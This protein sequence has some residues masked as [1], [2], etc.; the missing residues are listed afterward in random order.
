MAMDGA[1]SARWR[2]CRPN[3]TGATRPGPATSTGRWSTWPAGWGSGSSGRSRSPRSAALGRGEGRLPWWQ[4][5]PLL[6]RRLLVA[7]GSGPFAHTAVPPT[8][9]RPRSCWQGNDDGQG[10]VRH[11]AH[12]PDLRDEAGSASRSSR[13]QDGTLLVVAAGKMPA[14][15][16]EQ[17][18]PPT[19]RPGDGRVRSV[20]EG[21]DLL[22]VAAFQAGV[23][24][25]V[26]PEGCGATSGG[27]ADA[28]ARYLCDGWGFLDDPV[29]PAAQREY[30]IERCEEDRAARTRLLTAVSRLPAP[31]RGMCSAP[32]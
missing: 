4:V 29:R 18:F 21:L 1:C 11:P 6:Q 23:R 14:V 27:W 8:S 24:H 31:D 26:A 5:A 30:L 15:V 19:A 9:A 32:T 17:L 3:G 7:T 13:V 10:S 28:E 25:L 20:G 2:A 22:G 16:A 12:P